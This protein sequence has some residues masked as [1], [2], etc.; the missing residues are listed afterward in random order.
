MQRVNTPLWDHQVETIERFVDQD[1]V[2]CA[3]EMGTGKT[4]F[5]IERT[6]Q[7]E[8]VPTL[9]VAPLSTHDS[10]LKAWEIEAPH[11]RVKA[12]N[13]KKRKDFFDGKHHVYIMHYEALRLMPELVKQFDHAIFDECHRLKN[14]NSK[15]TKA[16]KKLKVPFL[17]DMSGSP[18]T[19]RP[20]D[21]WSV[22]NHLYPREYSS[23][24]RFF[25]NMTNSEQPI[26]TDE[27][28]KVAQAQYWVTYGPTEL[29]M[30]N[31][32][33]DIEPFYSRVLAKDCPDLHYARRPIMETTIHVDLTP[34]MR[35]AYK[36]MHDEMI[37]WVKAQDGDH[38]LVAPV[39][40]AKLQRLQQ[41]A[42]ATI[43]YDEVREAYAMVLPSPKIEAVVQLIADNEAEPIVVFSQ[44]KTPLKLLQRTL[45]KA[46]IPAVMFTGDED[47]YQRADNKK[48]FM[49][50]KAHVFLATIGAGGEG[51][52]GLQSVCRT[53]IFLDLDW[54]PM[55]NDQAIAR[56]QRAG[57]ERT[58]HI[59]TIQA[60]GTIDRDR[61]EKI[62]LKKKWVLQTLGDI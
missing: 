1:S 6:L 52:D 8:C 55:R 44:F 46:G 18:V 29:W 15:Q 20:Q 53:G 38:P 42:M 48:L 60:N 43:E 31:G 5:A 37:T 19:D 32:L 27:N 41:L 33:A 9:V 23:Y 22:L 17:T 4:L 13:P 3:W 39:L 49:E 11:L 35:R 30:T 61:K 28:G 26:I 12:I 2:L 54:S 36:E 62:E 47:H 24:W 34:K 21:I 51:V 58:V 57:Q 59:I 10:W 7:L 40:I 50:G 25:H 16:A 45:Q 56:L 14:R